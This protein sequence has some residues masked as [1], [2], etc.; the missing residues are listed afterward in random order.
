[1]A[2]TSFPTYHTAESSFTEP[3]I[4]ARSLLPLGNG[5]ASYK[6]EGDEGR[7]I[8]HLRKGALIGDVGYMDPRG[9]F[10]FSFNIFLPPSHPI[11][12]ENLP[13]Y[14]TPLSPPL[15]AEE[16]VTSPQHFSPGTVLASEGIDVLEKSRSPL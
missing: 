14:F 16:Y 15:S 4:Y 1:M 8:E 11:Q 13:T 7:S 2:D 5:Q 6:P 9:Y 10:H 3:Q 12:R